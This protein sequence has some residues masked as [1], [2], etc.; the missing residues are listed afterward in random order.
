MGAT[1]A[2]LRQPMENIIAQATTSFSVADVAA[3][4]SVSE[5]RWRPALIVGVSLP[6]QILMSLIR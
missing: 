6:E 5:V 2:G 3:R 1:G 4:L